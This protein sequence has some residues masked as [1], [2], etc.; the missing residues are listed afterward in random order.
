MERL[1]EARDFN[2]LVRD[3]LEYRPEN[4]ETM[5]RQL[6]GPTVAA[7][8]AVVRLDEFGQSHH[9]LSRRLINTL[10]VRQLADGSWGEPLV[11]ALALRALLTANGQGSA[12]QR[13]MHWLA[14]AQ[15]DDGL[16]QSVRGE[17]FPTDPFTSSAILYWLSEFEVFRLTVRFDDLV[18]WFDANDT[19]LDSA[20]VRLWARSQ[21]RLDAIEMTLGAMQT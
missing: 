14:S 10:L 15:R 17:R 5:L 1:F 6:T 19:Q 13:G 12:I 16:W 2:R 8:L 7:A 18:H 9:V 11:T 21:P 4:S 3:L 20:T